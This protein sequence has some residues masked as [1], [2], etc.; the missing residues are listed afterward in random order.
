MN[1]KK[2]LTKATV[3]VVAAAMVLTIAISL[4]S[5][6]AFADDNQLCSKQARFFLQIKPNQSV[7][8]CH[9]PSTAVWTMEFRPN[10]PGSDDGQLQVTYDGPRGHLYWAQDFVWQDGVKYHGCAQHGA[11]CW[12]YR[13][14]I[15]YQLGGANVFLEGPF[16]VRE[17]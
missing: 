6:T 16:V 3:T 9:S 11:V 4:M 7:Y 12:R 8:V 15:Y 1:M 14:S 13:P 2:A 17:K 10:Q 5:A